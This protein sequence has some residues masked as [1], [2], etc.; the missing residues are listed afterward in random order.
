MPTWLRKQL[1]EGGKVPINNGI[2]A[3]GTLGVKTSNTLPD[4]VQLCEQDQS[5][6]QAFLCHPGV[7]HVVKR[8]G[9]GVFTGYQNIQM[10]IS[11]IQA[12]HS[13]GLEHFQGQLPTVLRLQDLIEEAW[14]KGINRSERIK[15]GGIKGTRKWIGTVEVIGPVSWQTFVLTRIGSSVVR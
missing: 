14:D 12:A 10:L 9:E 1:E 5:L 4:L 2:R 15:T 7:K 3:D 13:Q 11:Y 8:Q 6:E